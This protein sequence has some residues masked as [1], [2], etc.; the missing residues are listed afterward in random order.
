MNSDSFHSSSGATELAEEVLNEFYAANDTHKKGHNHKKQV[1]FPKQLQS[2]DH[3][4]SV[5]GLNSS[6]SMGAFAFG[7]D[8]SANV[9]GMQNIFSSSPQVARFSH[10]HSQPQPN[11]LNLTQHI[12]SKEPNSKQSVGNNV[13]LTPLNVDDFHRVS[14]LMHRVAEVSGYSPGKQRLSAASLGAP[15][16][17]QGSNIQGRSMQ[18]SSRG[19]VVRAPPSNVDIATNMG[20]YQLQS[21]KENDGLRS[22]MEQVISLHKEL[23]ELI[24]DNLLHRKDLSAHIDG[25][26]KTYVQ[27]FERMLKEVLRTQRQKFKVGTPFIPVY[28]MLVSSVFSFNEC[29]KTNEMKDLCQ[30]K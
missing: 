11:R 28:H 21:L 26:N 9:G 7:S 14:D 5:R 15:S 17:E 4:D 13:L 23:Q 16:A 20:E 10:D 29:V 25:I 19:G 1:K 30:K 12:L 3:P 6:Q 22:V 2:I 18:P 8:T 24:V 27:L